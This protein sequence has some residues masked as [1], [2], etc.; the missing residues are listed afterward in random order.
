MRIDLN[1]FARNCSVTH[2]RLRITA[3]VFVA[4]TVF[5]GY[6]L[7]EQSAAQGGS[8]VVG[9]RIVNV[10]PHDPQAC[11]Q[12]L[13]YRNGCL[14]ESTGR[15]NCFTGVSL[16]FRFPVMGRIRPSCEVDILEFILWIK[17]FRSHAVFPIG[18]APV[19]IQRIALI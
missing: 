3:L 17:S 14:F 7:E 6:G 2:K 15:P 16:L 4:L 12:G 18:A 5:P 8:P 19:F 1:N 11:T 13:V 9:Y 10:Y